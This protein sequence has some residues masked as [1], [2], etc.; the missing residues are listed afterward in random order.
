[1]SGTYINL[2]PLLRVI[3]LSI[4]RIALIHLIDSG[5]NRISRP[6]SEMEEAKKS[7]EPMPD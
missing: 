4:N 2:L 6:R 3:D 5:S 7:N 1:M